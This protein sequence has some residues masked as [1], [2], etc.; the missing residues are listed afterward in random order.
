MC[1]R[2]S[3]EGTRQHQNH[4]QQHNRQFFHSVFSLFI[5]VRKALILQLCKVRRHAASVTRSGLSR[6]PLHCNIIKIHQPIHYKYCNYWYKYCRVAFGVK[7]EKIQ[8][9]YRK[10]KQ[11]ADCESPLHIH[12]FVR[13]TTSLLLRHTHSP[14]VKS[15][16]GC[17]APH[18][19]TMSASSQNNIVLSKSTPRCPSPIIPTFTLFIVCSL[20]RLRRFDYFLVVANAISFTLT[21][22]TE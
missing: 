16:T 5:I 7:L 3:R 22:F 8:K 10:S 18:T 20:K 11:I 12:Y 6:K 13:L 1:I 4:C 15:G 19:A 14:R 2:D 21:K 9:D 17:G